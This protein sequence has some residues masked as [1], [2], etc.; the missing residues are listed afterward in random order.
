MT[1]TR[2]TPAEKRIFLSYARGD[3]EA[4]V[5]R[6]NDDLAKAG[7]TVWFD[8][9]SLM[10]RGLTFHQE[11]KDA[12][13]TEVDRVVYVGGPKAALSQFVREE[14]QSAL[15]YD[16]VAVTPI[17]RLG[18]Y[19]TC[20]P[21]ELCLLHCEDFR[22]D[23][24]YEAA[25]KRLSASLGQ[26]NP[27]LGAL[28]AVPNLPPCFL[29]RP[30]LI[31]RVRDA[32]LVDLQKPQV[33]TSVNAKVGIQ[34]MGGIGKSVL[35]AALAR[36]RQIRQSYPDGVV[37]I[38]C[39]Q[40]LSDD[41]LLSRLRD[42]VKALGGDTAFT[43]LPQGQGILREM[44]QTKAVLLVLDDVWHAKDTQVFDVLGPRCK[45]L[46]TTRNAGIL[47]TLH[48]ESVPISLFNETES[49]QLLADATG[50]ASNALPHEAHEVVKE[51]GC[52]PLALALS[53]GMAKKH[54]GNFRSVLERLRHAD[55]E[56]IADRESINEQHRSI[57]RAMQASV[58]MLLEDEQKRFAE[59]AVFDTD[60]TVP[61]AAVAT[62]WEHTG[63]LDEF[64]SEDLLVNLAERSLIQLDQKTDAEG[65]LQRR[66]RLH[67]LL[68]DF[69]VRISKDIKAIH[70]T[71]L[72][73][74]WSKCRGGWH[75]GPNDGYFFENL[76]HHII[77]N[78]DW[79][80]LIGDSVAPGPL[81]DLRFVQAKCE[82]GLVYNLMCDYNTALAAVPEFREEREH[83]R[84]QNETMGTYSH[85]LNTFAVRRFQHLIAKER[86]ELCAEP[87][88]PQLP[89]IL[90][91]D[92]C[93]PIVEETSLR[94]AR[95]RHFANFVSGHLAPLSKYP[96]ETVP[97]AYNWSSE[98]PVA[99][100]AERCLRCFERPWLKRSPRP[101]APPFRPQ[102]VRMLEG[103]DSEVWTVNVSLDGRRVVSNDNRTVRIWDLETG[104]CLRTLEIHANGINSFCMSSDG[105]YAASVDSDGTLRSWD[106]GVGI[107]LRTIEGVGRRTRIMTLSS[108]GLHVILAYVDSPLQLWDLKTGMCLRTFGPD[109]YDVVSA[110][111]CPDGRRVVFASGDRNVR[112]WDLETGECLQTLACTTRACGN[113]KISIRLK[114]S[115]VLKKNVCVSPDGR[116]LVSS[117]E[118]TLQFWELETGA[119]LRILEGCMG[120]IDSVSVSR[121][122]RRVIAN[123]ERTV[124]VWDLES[125]VCLWTLEG[126]G[127]GMN[128]FC[129]SP[130]GRHAVSAGRDKTVR[131]W[132]TGNEARLR[133][134]DG[135][136]GE[137][138][139]VSLS[140][141]GRRVVSVS[142][143]RILRIWDLETGRCLRMFNNDSFGVL[144]INQD[145]R[146]AV[147]VGSDKSLVRWDMET[148]ASLRILD[149]H[150]DQVKSVSVSP[151]VQHAISV[152]SDGT[153]RIWNLDIGVCLSSL[154]VSGWGGLSMSR[155]PD[156][157]RAVSA[158]YGRNMHFWDLETGTCLQTLKGHRYGVTSVCVCHDG[159]RAVSASYDMTVRIWDLVSG[160]C[161][162]TLKGHNDSISKVNV[163]PDGR[164][165]VSV[166]CDGNVRIWS[167]GS[168]KCVLS[169]DW[170]LALVDSISFSMDGR[171]II[172]TSKDGAVRVWSLETGTPL[173]TL[174]GQGHDIRNM[175]MD[176]N[177][178]FV[179]S[180]ACD[181][182]LKISDIEVSACQSI[183]FAY[184][185]L[186]ASAVSFDGSRLVCGTED[187]QMHFLTIVRSH[188]TILTADN[189]EEVRCPLC[190]TVFSPPNHVVEVINQLT[191]GL[192]KDTAPCRIVPDSAF[193]DQRLLSSCPHCGKPL[194]FNPFFV[195]PEK[196]VDTLRRGLEHSRREKGPYHEETLAHLEALVVNLE[197][198]G[199]ADEA[200]EFRREQDEVS[201]KLKE[202]QHD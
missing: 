133:V 49:L 201:A 98:G 154:K 182:V 123:N 180:A 168:G 171:R 12:I 34:G 82:A 103:H 48:G 51:C 27:N 157:R 148:G 126:H 173:R 139:S 181:K 11:I 151:D 191:V 135:H 166:G 134:L 91:N 74:Y 2:T 105:Q 94:A 3:D 69:A 53:G 144:N 35:A 149:G 66:L 130:D 21:G 198:T 104:A 14:W 145:G 164:Y 196:Y 160:A 77:S 38:A 111:L 106:L 161:L 195:A 61:E 147:M 29:G 158:G 116:Y 169:S 55:L 100:D 9:D 109:R 183:Y 117:Y 120:R 165:A 31:C 136:N 127:G 152:G 119:F 140:R 73:A 8:R 81:T 131:L 1:N 153:I 44:L 15:E 50:V 172:I 57:W 121:D 39:C 200:T 47:H 76:C 22:E 60:G 124:R 20:V 142:H 26:P 75:T 141:D 28:F 72:E 174:I 37:W 19:E 128:S 79:A 188:P 13:R 113:T 96:N 58:E 189:I 138:F 159:Q 46:I 197:N 80:A 187:G 178:R 112:I 16:H 33:I 162:H 97:L 92:Y 163:S 170:N 137:V 186:T 132:N 190:S 202:K 87:D 40:H 10:S 6:L 179:I 155:S 78:E 122:A 70:N 36:N 146:Y 95:L 30:E 99:E 71:L 67:D 65:K 150:S 17:L 43:S 199:K 86:G 167:L 5:R 52:L 194:K 185:N 125:G 42:L 24:K 118:N 83:L 62:L 23:E 88:Y 7:F 193:G 108:N 63:K 110:C 18:D 84:R 143:D 107:C 68:Y 114:R 85:D 192:G 129:I 41:D 156:G 184:S 4:F 64:D 54:G 59:L 177:A 115:Y 89:A 93:P 176:R 175:C 45:M 102:C 32:L 56:K 90:S 25:L 101:P